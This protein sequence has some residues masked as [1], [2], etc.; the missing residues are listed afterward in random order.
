VQ[1]WTALQD[2]PNRGKRI[3]ILYYNNPPG[4]GALGASYLNIFGSMANILGTLQRAGYQTGDRLP[5]EKDLASLLEMSG[6]N[7]EL[8]APGE[9]D[10]RLAHGVAASV[11]VSKYKRWPAELPAA[12]R[13]SVNKE[14]GPPQQARLRTTWWREP[15]YRFSA[16]LQLL[17]NAC[18]Q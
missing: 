15:Q 3:A 12:F 5:T 7:I 10:A 18:P 4:K 8:W 11:P 13:D 1:R 9:L 14:W 6:R 17:S 2:K 16:R